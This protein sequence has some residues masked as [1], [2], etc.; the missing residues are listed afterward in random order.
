MSV[1]EAHR[2]HL[3]QICLHPPRSAPLMVQGVY[4]PFDQEH[5]SSIYKALN[6]TCQKQ[7]HCV[8]LGDFIAAMYPTDRSSQQ[9]H[10]HDNRHKEAMMQSGL[11]PTDR[12][13][14]AYTYIRAS[15]TGGS[16]GQSRID[17]IFITSAIPDP[18]WTETAQ[19]TDDSDHLPLMR[20]T[21]DPLTSYL[22]NRKPPF[23][24][25]C[26]PNLYCQ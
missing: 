6:E 16:A 26:N 4:M 9:L 8:V 15:T 25:H 14:R 13:V 19:A 21:L 2:S 11:R 10:P 12:A 23:P 3:V 1:L 17:D 18:T 5:R 20:W 24:N 22:W 7:K